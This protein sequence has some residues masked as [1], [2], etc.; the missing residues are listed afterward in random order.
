MFMQSNSTS[1]WRHRSGLTM[2]ALVALAG[3]SACGS[4]DSGGG[5]SAPGPEPTSES[6]P[7]TDAT[8]PTSATSETMPDGAESSTA[9]TAPTTGSTPAVDAA[10]AE[11][12]ERL[13]LADASAIEILSVEEVTWP[14]R[15]LGCPQKGMQYAQV[16]TPG[17][18]IV[19][20]HDGTSYSYHGGNGR[21]PFYCARPQAPAPD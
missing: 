9:V 17:I 12:V 5:S 15:A 19:L 4:D 13:G 7:G 1:P 11:L 6:A 16:L 8:P 20:A 10:V 14:D 3:V 21:L 18:R 2:L